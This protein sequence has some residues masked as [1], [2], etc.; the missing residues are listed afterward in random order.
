[1]SQNPKG[2]TFGFTENANLRQN[3]RNSVFLGCKAHIPDQLHIRVPYI[4]FY[5]FKKNQIL[6][7]NLKGLA[8][9]FTKSASL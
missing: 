2:F 6:A 5:V 4:S 8:F 1:L 9:D 7:K 3:D